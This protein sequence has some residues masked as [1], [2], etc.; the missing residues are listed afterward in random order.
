MQLTPEICGE[1]WYPRNRP[2]TEFEAR[3]DFI[4]YTESRKN[5][6]GQL[7]KR[8]GWPM[9]K[10][11]QLIKDIIA[12]GLKENEVQDTLLEVD[13]N[14]YIKR[15]VIAIEVINLFNAVFDR[16]IGLN[17]HR[18]RMIVARIKEG[19]T[20]KPPVGIDQFRAVFEFK[21]KEWT[22]TEQEKYLTISTLC[23]PSHFQDYLEAARLDYKSK[24]KKIKTETVGV[25]LDVPMFT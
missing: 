13:Y 16:D 19:A 15:K 12:E 11:R 1:K 4:L 17:D 7:Y 23:A 25:K 18:T 24:Q 6:W 14:K 8:W 22:G 3:V 10:A 5:Q 9:L 21:K 2:F 20:N